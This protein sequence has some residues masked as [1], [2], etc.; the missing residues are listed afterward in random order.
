MN[1]N[2]KGFHTQTKKLKPPCTVY[3]MN[4]PLGSF[5][6]NGDTWGFHPQTQKLRFVDR[7]KKTFNL[8]Y[9]IAAKRVE[10]RCRAFYHSH[11]TCEQHY[12]LQDRFDVAGKNAQ[13][14]HSTRF[15]A[16]L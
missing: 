15:V 6:L 4:V 2:T 1:G 5:H 12:L 3:H 7:D 14:R 9:I 16:M 11:Q 10:K 8:F 13:H